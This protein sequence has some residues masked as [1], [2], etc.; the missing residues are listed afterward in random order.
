MLGQHSVG[1]LRRDFNWCDGARSESLGKSYFLQPVLFSAGT[2]VILVWRG[3][4]ASL[5]S[6]GSKKKDQTN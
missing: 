3:A 1:L 5:V 2:T 4:I 6:S